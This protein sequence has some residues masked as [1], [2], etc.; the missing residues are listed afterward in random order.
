MTDYFALA[1]TQLAEVD[2]SIRR[3]HKFLMYDETSLAITQNVNDGI[4]RTDS[5]MRTDSIS[6]PKRKRRKGIIMK[7]ATAKW[8]PNA[9]E[10]T[11]TNLNL[12]VTPGRLV[13]VIGP[14]G[15]GKSSLLQTILKELPLI[16]GSV[17]INGIISYASQEPWLFTGTVRQNILFGRPMNKERYKTVI[18]KCALARDFKLFP[19]GDRTLVGER[20]ISLSGGQRARINLARAVYKKADIYLLDDPLSAVDTHVG[21]QLFESCISTYLCDKTCIL[22]THQLQHLKKVD[23]IIILNNGIIEAEGSYE[24]LKDS[25]LD[26]AKL[27]DDIPSYDEEVK[28]RINMRRGSVH[29]IGS[30]DDEKLEAPNEL[31]ESRTIGSVSPEVYKSYFKSGGNCCTLFV[32]ISL[33]LF[34]QVAASSGDYFISYW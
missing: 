29:S 30:V 33:F 3:V 15:S 18:H 1:I 22:V 27:L 10:N 32:L 2:I 8:Q 6:D 23:Q 17:D 19:H 5:L 13:A 12:K 24:E 34:A 21:K 11:L 7:N 25:G 9:A 14:V 31:Q 20:G 4:M 26:F 16:S 28:K